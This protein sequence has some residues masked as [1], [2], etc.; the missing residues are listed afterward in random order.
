LQKSWGCGTDAAPLNRVRYFG[1]EDDSVSQPAVEFLWQGSDCGA[2][3][4][5]YRPRQLVHL[6][7]L[8][9][10]RGAN[11]GPGTADDEGSC[12]SSQSFDGL[13]TL[14]TLLS[15]TQLSR[16]HRSLTATQSRLCLYSSIVLRTP[17]RQLSLHHDRPRHK[18]ETNHIQSQDAPSRS[19]ARWHAAPDGRE[20]RH[21]R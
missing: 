10:G 3:W 7:R 15:D 1:R 8:D 12:W 4:G 17:G 5:T 2:V 18:K 20:G 11:C 9:V 13:S 21:L 14:P 16:L 6:K 19:G